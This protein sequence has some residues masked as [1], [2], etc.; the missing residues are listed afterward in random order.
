MTAKL[1]LHSKEI[2][3]D[4]IIEIKVWQ[5]PKSTEKP[6]GVKFSIAYINNGKRL[7]GYDNAQQSFAVVYIGDR[8]LGYDNAEGK[9]YHKHRAGIEKPYYFTTIW[10]LLDDFRKDLRKLRGRDWDEG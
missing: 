7:L 2:K 6:H 3:E 8:L 4:E 9:G 5:V 1:L 10:Q